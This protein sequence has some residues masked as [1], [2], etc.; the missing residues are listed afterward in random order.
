MIIKKLPSFKK[1]L[2][3]LNKRQTIKSITIDNEVLAQSIE[4]G[5]VQL[6]AR[7]KRIYNF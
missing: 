4:E 7:Q 3:L 2:T 6:N 1:S 5:K